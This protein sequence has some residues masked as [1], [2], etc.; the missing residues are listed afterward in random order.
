M[1]GGDAGS[2]SA[3]PFAGDTA[4]FYARYR[5]DYPV[6]FVARL[7]EFNHGGMGRLLDVGCGTGQLL[8]QLAGFFAQAVG[9]DP[10]PDM[11]KVAARLARERRIGNVEWIKAS[12]ADLHELEPTIGRFA[13]VTIGTAFHFMEPR[14]TLEH[15]KRIAAG[16]V[17]VVAYNG[18]PMWLHQ[19]RWAR[20]LRDVLETRLG[21]PLP[22][23]DFTLEA[24]HAA[25]STMH[26]LGYTGIERWELTR[27]ESIDLE[28]VVGHILSATSA[29]QIPPAERPDFAREVSAAIRSVAPSGKV[30]ES[31]TVRAVIGR[32]DPADRGR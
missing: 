6:E 2:G 25:E 19:D 12:S 27:R 24:L 11:L 32:S 3:G 9:I 28:F 14:S 10:E 22:E 8:L 16:G 26:E 17:V 15:L 7:D 29:G 31:V 20:N 4:T 21:G 5:R 1:G 30:V 13:L 23:G 18:S